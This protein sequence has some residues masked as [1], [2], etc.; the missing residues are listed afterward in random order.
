MM[1]LN[2][3]RLGSC[4]MVQYPRGAF[5][6]WRAQGEQLLADAQA[7]P[8]PNDT[9]RYAWDQER[10]HRNLL[11]CNPAITLER[12]QAASGRTVAVYEVGLSYGGPE[13]G[14]WW[15][16]TGTVP[17]LTEPYTGK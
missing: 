12:L 1:K 6:H 13:E 3:Y 7:D 8:D 10:A 16:R 17:E 9:G 15:F 5:G 2:T 14:G 11:S 4:V